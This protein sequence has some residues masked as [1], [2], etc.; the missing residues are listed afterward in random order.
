MQY[1]GGQSHP[2]PEHEP[3]KRSIEKVQSPGQD[4]RSRLI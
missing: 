1:S 2:K 3:I 4:P